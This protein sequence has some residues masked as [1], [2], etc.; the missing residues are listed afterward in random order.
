[1]KCYHCGKP[2]MACP[3]CP[4]AESGWKGFLHV[5]PDGAPGSHY[6]GIS[7]TAEPAAEGIAS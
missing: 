3:D 4:A 7:D 2:I 6:C 1:M 5:K